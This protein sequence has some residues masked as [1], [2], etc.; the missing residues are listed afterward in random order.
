MNRPFLLAAT[1]VFAC[2]NCLRAGEL[3]TCQPEVVGLS[4]AK[5]SELAPALTKLVADG[6]IPGAVAL[7]ARHGKVAHVTAVGYRDLAAKSPMTEDTIFAIASMSKPVTCVAAMMLVEQGKLGLDDP[8]EKYLPEL[9]SQRVLGDAKDDTKEQLATVALKRPVAIRDLFAHTSGFAYG[10]LLSASGSGNRLAGAYE[11]A[12]LA[13]SR[14]HS[15]AELTERL[16]KVPLAHQPGEG[17]TYGLSHD[18][19]GRIIEVVAGQ[20]F[21]QYLHEHIFAPLDMPDTSFLVPEAKRERVA[22]IYRAEDGKPLAAIPVNYGSATFFSGGGGLF[23]TIRD[24]TRFATMLANGGELDGYRVLKPESI[25]TMTSNQIGKQNAFGLIKYGLGFGLIS[26]PGA[27]GEK[28]ALSRYFWGGL[29][30]TNFWIDP[31]HD[32]VAVVMTQVLPTNHGGAERVLGDVVA[33][34]IDQ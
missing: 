7:V 11:R 1:V 24:Y 26:A 30:S 9:K 28:P 19:L 16:A 23:S 10:F 6:K 21:D 15:L 25:A 22:R 31:R 20:G 8:V 4:S 2:G 3:P 17:W 12:G 14:A 18:V 27:R 13:H 32:L 29:Y 5:L 34:A 33:K